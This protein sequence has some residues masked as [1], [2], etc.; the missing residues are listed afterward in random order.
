MKL[1]ESQTE[2]YDILSTGLK[3][4]S[5]SNSGYVPCEYILKKL[6][7]STLQLHFVKYFASRTASKRLHIHV[8]TYIYG[9]FDKIKRCYFVEIT[10]SRL[11]QKSRYSALFQV[12]LPFARKNM[13]PTKILKEVFHVLVISFR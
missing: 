7:E 8:Y 12:A 5:H 3:V 13:N 1:E 11:H 9:T 6:R 4:Y 10:S 2:D